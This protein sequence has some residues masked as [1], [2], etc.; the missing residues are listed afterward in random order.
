M[1]I[2]HLTSHFNFNSSPHIYRGK[3]KAKQGAMHYDNNNSVNIN[4]S[5]DKNRPAK[6]VNFGGSA[7]LETQKIVNKALKELVQ[8]GGKDF[9]RVKDAPQWA[10]NFLNS[11]KIAW[12]LELVKNNEAL[13]E[14]IVTIFLAGLLKPICVLAMPGAPEED[15]QAAATKNFVA[16]VTGFA[17]STLILTPVSKGVKKV[18]KNL[19]KYIKD[20]EY[21]KLIDP[22]EFGEEVLKVAKNG[23]KL[24]AG[25]LADAY[26]TF[27]KKAADMAI[28]PTKAKITIAFMPYLLNFLFKRDKKEPKEE[29][30]VNTTQEKLLEFG[31]NEQV[32]S[33]FMGGITK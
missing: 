8:E 27:Y 32:Y 25:D 21:I 14:N 28:T 26:S 6:S 16:A 9:A 17:L 10:V 33:K 18:T 13:F 4:T 30:T 3:D 24:R 12:V 15:K 19:P 1:R 22:N 23:K 29:Q 7:G 5:T 11:K 2:E 31:P 20:P